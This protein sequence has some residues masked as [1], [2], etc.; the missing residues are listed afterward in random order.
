MH[1]KVKV[2][3]CPMAP[4]CSYAANE[5]NDVADHAKAVHDG[6]RDVKCPKCHFTCA[7]R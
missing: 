1:R 7:I 2:Y 4:A 5:R 6:T 3:K